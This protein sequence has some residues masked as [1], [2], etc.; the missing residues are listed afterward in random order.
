MLKMLHVAVM[1]S[2]SS[3]QLLNLLFIYLSFS[4]SLETAAATR[5]EELLLIT[6]M[7]DEALLSADTAS[8]V[9][10]PHPPVRYSD[11]VDFTQI[12]EQ[13]PGLIY[14]SSDLLAMTRGATDPKA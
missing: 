2:F 3:K 7:T 12:S 5:G 10:P 4:F 9:R 11:K 6:L 13:S 8:N 1:V 14:L